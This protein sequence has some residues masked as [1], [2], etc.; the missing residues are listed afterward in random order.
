MAD[1]SFSKMSFITFHH[2]IFEIHWAEECEAKSF[3]SNL[4]LSVEYQLGGKL[5]VNE[6]IER[7]IQ[8]R[9]F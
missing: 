1:T 6:P 2:L 5:G 8:R 4:D 3:P 7:D 9:T